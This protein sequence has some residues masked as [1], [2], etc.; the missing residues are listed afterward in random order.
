MRRGSTSPLHQA[1]L[2]PGSPGASPAP[3]GGRGG[4]GMGTA[5]GTAGGVL[6]PAPAR[7]WHREGAGVSPL[8]GGGAPTTERKQTK[9]GT[10]KGPEQ[11]LDSICVTQNIT[12][13]LPVSCGSCLVTP[14]SELSGASLPISSLSGSGDPWGR[15]A[16]DGEILP[17]ACKEAAAGMGTGTATG[18]AAAKGCPGFV[19]AAEATCKHAGRELLTFR[20]GPPNKAS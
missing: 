6:Q 12:F 9:P 7:L 10:G 5:L 2:N 17:Q 4:T 18:T 16:K 3:A 19:P 20:R 8:R 11:V 1:G 14:G 15:R 13:I